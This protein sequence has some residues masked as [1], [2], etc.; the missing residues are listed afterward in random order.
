VALSRISDYMHHWSDVLAGSILGC[1]VGVL[2]E[3]H[4]SRRTK[5]AKSRAQEI[6]LPYH[7]VKPGDGHPSDTQF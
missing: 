3:L 2:M 1:F 4:V 7:V 6:K 5:E